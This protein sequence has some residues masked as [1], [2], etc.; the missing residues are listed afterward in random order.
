MYGNVY[1]LFKIIIIITTCK[2]QDIVCVL[3]HQKKHFGLCI[4]Q[5]TESYGLRTEYTYMAFHSWCIL[6]YL[7]QHFNQHC[8]WHAIMYMCQISVQRRQ[9]VDI[10]THHSQRGRSACAKSSLNPFKP[11]SKFSCYKLY[12]NFL[13]YFIINVF[14]VLHMKEHKSVSGFCIQTRICFTSCHVIKPTFPKA[15]TNSS[16]SK[17]KYIY[18]TFLSPC[19]SKLNCEYL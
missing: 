5:N 13:I 11:S 18:S 7:N 6:N 16:K 3:T 17:V 9:I 10:W 1:K 15:S 12:S 8:T 2:Y 19:W 4:Y 14:R